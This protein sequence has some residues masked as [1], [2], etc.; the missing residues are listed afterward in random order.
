MFVFFHAPEEPKALDKM[1]K[2]M[3]RLNRTHTVWLW[4]TE[5]YEAIRSKWK[6]AAAKGG[7]SG[8]QHLFYMALLGRDWKLRLLLGYDS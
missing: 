6:E 8:A 5:H 4:N 2:R 3:N 1:E 7:M